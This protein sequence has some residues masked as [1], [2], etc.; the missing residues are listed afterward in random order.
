MV[1]AAAAMFPIVY[2]A[3]FAIDVPHWF[4]YSRNLQNRADAAALAAGTAFGTTCFAGGTP[5]TT[6][7]GAQ[8]AIG[9]WAQ[10]YSGAGVNEPAGRL[11]YSDAAVSA[12]TNAAPGTGNGPGTGWPVATRGY[13]NNTLPASPVLSPLTLKLG[14]LNNYY[15][16]LNGRNY[17]ENGG[18]SFSMNA[19]GSG[20]TFCNSDPTWDL[21]DP[22]RATAGP[23]GAFVDVKVSQRRLPLFFPLIGGRPTLH[24]HA[25]VQ[26]QG[27]A[28]SPSTPIA[29]SD[30]G[31]TPC[32]S[33][34]FINASTNALIQTVTLT[35]V[36]PAVPTDPVQWDNSAAP[37]SFTMPAS[38]NVYLQPFLSNCNGDGTRYD[39]D[40]N[41]GMLFINNHPAADPTVGGG[42]A[43]QLTPGGVALTGTCTSSTQYFSVGACSVTINAFVKFDPALQQN[44]TFVLAY[45]RIWD[46]VNNVYTTTLLGNQN[47][48]NQSNTDPTKWTQS[49]IVPDSSG[50]HQIEIR[51]RQ[52][53][54]SVGGTACGNGNGGN[55]QPCTGTFGIQTQAFGA[56]NGCDQPDD[57][58]P[59]IFARISEGASNDVNTFAGGSTHNLVVTLKLAGLSA[60]QGGDPATVLR[61]PTSGNHQTGLV[62][63]GQG[64]GANADGYVV[65]YG[66]GPG[67]PQFPNLNPLFVNTRNTCGTPPGPPWPNGNEQDCVQTTPGTRRTGIIC[68]LVQRIT[69]VPLGG[70]CNNNAVGQ[71]PH[72]YWNNTDQP[73]YSPPAGDPRAVT[74]IVT[75]A[76]DFGS[77]VGSPQGWV[78][79]RRFAT[80][81]ITGWDSSIKPQC[82]DNE[83]FP[84]RGKRNS[85]NAAVWG[86][87]INYL[88]TA[89]TPN[90]QGCPL[91]S[92]QP[93]NCVPALTR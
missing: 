68:P 71:C 79:V 74:M 59:I 24:A 56:C 26:L 45:D 53:T 47:G 92:V 49:F 20:A 6:G 50:M 8:G 82:G 48:M 16:V 13:L 91:A 85:Q 7:N 21:T 84:T 14:S 30:N 57:S 1:L 81:Y 75:S 34:D 27:E 12:A 33:V 29:V 86:H 46:N 38:A 80:F 19:A 42:Q 77:V 76:A 78:P 89:G 32:V 28:S 58:G 93:I 64:G 15:L 72:N 88:D 31:F 65:Y 35:K 55:P 37:A 22:S 66:C 52:E 17:A 67:N 83:S 2:L 39:S 23:A 10:L 43:P 63:C 51:W 69:H 44:K 36:P 54:G 11:P 41:T 5:G 61:F 87:W 90:G 60:A 73:P 18:T 4:D 62:D 9:K 25:R 70:P 3:A 40:T